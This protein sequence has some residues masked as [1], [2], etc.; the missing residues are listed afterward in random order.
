MASKLQP[1]R[2]RDL[3]HALCEEAAVDGHGNEGESTG[4]R[5]NIQR[6]KAPERLPP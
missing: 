5:R 2:V 6:S 1:D 3:L 4:L